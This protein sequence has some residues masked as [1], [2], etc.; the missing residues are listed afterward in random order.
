MEIFAL[1]N[2]PKSHQKC[3]QYYPVTIPL[4]V[5]RNG[6]TV[7]SL[8][9]NWLEHMSD[10]FRKG[11][12]LVNSVFS[13]GLVNGREGTAHPS[14]GPS[15]PCCLLSSSQPVFRACPVQKALR[16]INVLRVISE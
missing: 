10:H 2:K 14:G 3:R 12:V 11:G 13:L 5:S 15:E 6:Q 7:S 16:R 8:D 1:F 4:R 9:A